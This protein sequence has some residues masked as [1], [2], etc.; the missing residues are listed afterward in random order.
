MIIYRKPYDIWIEDNFLSDSEL[1]IIEDA[2]PSLNSELWYRER[3]YINEKKNK[4]EQGMMGISDLSVLKEDFRNL[5]EGFHSEDFNEKIK[6]I[7]SIK[8]DMVVDDTFRWTGLRMMLPDSFQLIHSDARRHPENKLRKE[9]TCLFYLNRNWK[10]SD[11]GCLEAWDDSMQKSLE[12]E[13][14]YN[15]LVVFRNTDT[16]YHGVPKVNKLRKMI[17][18]SILVDGESINR[19]KAQFV[20]RPGVD[21][22]EI[23]EIGWYRS[24]VG[25]KK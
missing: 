15:R 18:W 9:F 10:S 20:A 25:D 19:T 23:N 11:K 24:K 13:P 17:T 6:S 7:F 4:L 8:D 21:D 16:S 3:G 12:I 5:V 14:L 1:G 22:D 2:W